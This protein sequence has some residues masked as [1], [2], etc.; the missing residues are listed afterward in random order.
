MALAVSVLWLK[1]L[2]PL[3]QTFCLNLLN[4]YDLK[5][6]QSYLFGQVATVC[7]TDQSTKLDLVERL[8]IENL[9]LRQ[10]RVN[11]FLNR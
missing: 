7:F 3:L 6:Y 5:V 10:Y 11:G 2:K 4:N 9:N 8:I 1:R